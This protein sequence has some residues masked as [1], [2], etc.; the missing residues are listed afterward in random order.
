MATAP[1]DLWRERLT[2]MAYRVGEA[3]LYARTTPQTIGRW[4][5]IK[6]KRLGTVSN[7]NVRKALSY[8]ELIEL[9]VVVAMRQSGVTLV[10]IAQAREYLCGQFNTRF[11][12]AHYRFNTDGESSRRNGCRRPRAVPGHGR[13][14]YQVAMNRRRVRNPP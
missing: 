3:A 12:F 13:C 6:H 2:A 7:R 1:L 8:A 5:R 11:P 14:R 9:S 10:K 4:E